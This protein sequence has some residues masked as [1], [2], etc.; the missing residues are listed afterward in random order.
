MQQPHDTQ[1]LPAYEHP[2]DPHGEHPT[3]RFAPVSEPGSASPEAGR[4]RL[5]TGALVGLGVLASGAAAVPDEM[6]FAAARALAEIVS[7]EDLSKGC[8]F[9]PLAKIRSVSC[10]IARAVAEMAHR[11]GLAQKPEPEDWT[12]H[13]ES[14]MYQPVYPT[15]A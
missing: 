9:P 4:R 8:L 13:I 15:L 5:G 14:L 10:A 2:A 1:R 12:D 6:F 7:A 11:R 3:E